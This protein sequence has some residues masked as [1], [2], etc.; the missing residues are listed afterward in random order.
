MSIRKV[1]RGSRSFYEAVV[2]MGK[3]STGKRRQR[4]QSFHT[5]REA[6]VAEAA[7]KADINKGVAVD[8]SRQ[9]VA[10]L[11]QYWLDTYAVPNCRP[12][13]LEGYTRTITRHIVPALGNVPAQKLTPAMVQQFYADLKAA[14]VGA[15]QQQLCHIR[16][17]QALK[18][19]VRL[20]LVARNV[21]QA[22]TPPRYSTPVMHV[23]TATEARQY[24]DVA[25][26]RGRLGPLWLLALMTG[27]RKGEMLGLRWTDVDIAAGVLDVKQAQVMVAHRPRIGPPKSSAALRTVALPEEVVA[28]LRAHKA[29]QGAQR[30]AAG[31]DWHAE[32]EGLVFT[33]PEG[34][35][36]RPAR[37]ARELA[38]LTTLAGVPRIRVHDMRHTFVTQALASGAD[39]KAV[40]VHVG[41]SQTSMTLNRYAHALPHQR[42]DIARRITTALAAP[43]RADALVD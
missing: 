27:L 12:T 10:G 4:S 20:E 31:P 3:D 25:A 6:V 29:R 11:L 21:A 38:R 22:V 40:S 30:L 17:S 37:V 7:W 42:A 39:L 1:T 36:V 18:H 41:H 2:D 28:A 35:M 33:T 16:L 15:A 32:G 9:T 34:D 13:T 23:W 26:D 43:T 19:A 14:G 5:K 24:L 8:T